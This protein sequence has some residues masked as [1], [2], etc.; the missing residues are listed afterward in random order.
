[1]SNYDFSKARIGHTPQR[2]EVLDVY[3][4]MKVLQESGDFEESTDAVSFIDFICSFGDP[5]QTERPIVFYPKA[6]E[7]TA[8][9]YIREHGVGDNLY[10]ESL[11]PAFIGETEDGSLC[12]DYGLSISILQSLVGCNKKTAEK[13]LLYIIIPM[14]EDTGLEAPVFICSEDKK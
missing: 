2:K 8:S 6:E 3:R 13:I 11:G 5:N 4:M 12:Y 1:M 9:E 7:E 10:L 14:G